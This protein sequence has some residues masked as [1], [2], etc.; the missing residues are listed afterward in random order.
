MKYKI[1]SVMFVF[2]FVLLF[3]VFLYV[4]HISLPDKCSAE[5]LILHN[6]EIY[7]IELD[8]SILHAENSGVISISGGR[9]GG[10]I[11]RDVYFTWESN[12]N[13]YILK[14]TEIE[15]IGAVNT[16]GNEELR[17]IIPDFYIFPG[18]KFIY[19]IKKQGNDGLM[20]YIGR[21]PVFFCGITQS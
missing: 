5:V 21:R 13:S 14:S 10:V 6:N 2:V 15:V 20:F 16:I 8:I 4:R 11:R 17:K 7:N 3:G 1:M 9:K 12:L 18:K 19:S